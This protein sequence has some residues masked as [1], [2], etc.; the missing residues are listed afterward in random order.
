MNDRNKKVLRN[1]EKTW[2]GTDIHGTDP[3]VVDDLKK[4]DQE[5]LGGKSMLFKTG[6]EN[7]DPYN[8]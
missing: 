6:S 5:Y 2:S 7:S 8:N 4:F 1:E 3:L